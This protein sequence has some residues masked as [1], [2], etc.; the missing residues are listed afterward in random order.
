MKQQHILIWA[1]FRIVQ[2]TLLVV[3]CFLLPFT[4]GALSAGAAEEAIALFEQANIAQTQGEYQKAVE[5]YLTIIRSDGV[6]APLL[7]N[8][9]DSYAAG[10]QT[11]SAVLNYERALRLA[12][13]DSAV[14]A[15]LD[16]VRKDAGL[17]RDDRPLYQRL[18][19]LLGADQWLMIFGFVFVLLSISVLT[20]NLVPGWGRGGFVR[21][22]TTS[23]LFVLFLTLPPVLL[24]YQE[25]DIGVVLEEDARLLISPFDDAASAGGI[26][27]G[28]VIRPGRSHGEYVLIKDETGKSG[29]LAQDSF[30][31]V[32][33][34]PKG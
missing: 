28:R 6:S 25:W 23:S 2:T 15:N 17:Y 27:A 32:T 4:A 13:G 14:Q 21:C 11:G 8:L 19:A 22:L 12:P 34:L 30:E 3:F 16:Q 20:A 9:A 7:Y 26:K 18:P 31:R 10:G 29:W 24:R 5:L 1:F 33:E